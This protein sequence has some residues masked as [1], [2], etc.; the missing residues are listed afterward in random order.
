[1]VK[2]KKF[3][4]F[5]G[6]FTPSI[7]TIL[8]VIM[9]LRLPW[10]IGQ[11]G[12]WATLGIILV[13]HIISLSTGLSVASVA[14]DKQVETGGSYYIISRSLGLSI[15]GT[16]G[17]ALF[18]GLSFSVSLYLIGFAETFLSYFGF[19]VSLFTIRIAGSIILFLVALVTFISTSLAI[20]T[21]YLIMTAMVL[22]LVSVFFGR[23]DFVPAEPLFQGMRG[24]LPW[25][26]LFAIYFPAV[27]GFEAGVSMSGDLKN[28]RKDIP[29]GTISAIL[30]GLVV[31]IGLAFFFSHTVERDLLVNDPNVLFNIS[32]IPQLVIAGILGATLSSA[33]G[34]ILGA[35]RILQAV[36]IDRIIPRFLGKGY[37]PSNEP[38]NALMIT[39]VIAQAGI[40]IG[41]LNV[42][43]RVVTIFFIIT[44]GFL[45]ITYAVESWASSDFRPSFK[46][47]RFVSI[48]GALAC[49]VVMI[50]LDIIALLVASVV[51][52]ALFL[53]LKRKELTLQTGDTWNSVWT[54]VVKTGLEK[55]TASSRESR[56]WRP[57]V[58][59]FS[60]GE[61]S[62]PHLIEMGKS[63]VGKLGIFTN[64]ELVEDPNSD[65]IFREH[66]KNTFNAPVLRK[67]GV[68]T[69]RH[70]CRDFYE[71]IDLI[72]RVYGFSG[73][74]PNTIFMG[75]GRKTRD[76]Q[77]FAQL[78]ENFKKQD[79]NT[80][81]LNYNSDAGFGNYKQ[82]DF[83]WTGSG[84]NLSLAL[85]LLRF[86]TSSKEWMNASLRILVINQDSSK[87]ESLYHLVQQLLDQSRL[88]ASVKVIN[89]GVEQ[90]P[91]N[92]II[93]SESTATD[94]TILEL[95]EPSKKGV[96][97]NEKTNDL[98]KDLK[99]CL[100]VRASTFFD[101]INLSPGRTIKEKDPETMEKHTPNVLAKLTSPSR[102]IVAK[103]VFNL[104]ETLEDMTSR[105]YSEAYEAVSGDVFSFY[106]DLGNY[107]GKIIEQLRKV[108]K[109]VE[110]TAQPKAF[111]RIL[112][113][114]SFQARKRIDFLKGIIVH[115]QEQHLE[116][117]N[118]VYVRDSKLMLESLPEYLRIQLKKEDFETVS[119]DKFWTSTYKSFQRFR[120]KLRGKQ[121]TKKIRV[122]EVARYFLYLR[123]MEV[124]GELMND[125]AI[126]AFG[127]V[128]ALRKI[129]TSL[130]EVIEMT[131]IEAGDK[132]K[133][134]EKLNLEKDRIKAQLSLLESEARAFRIEAGNKLFDSLL[135]DLQ[136]FSNYLDN[137]G[138]NP[139]MKKFLKAL[140]E[141]KQEQEVTFLELPAL[142]E[143]SMNLFINKGVLDF[144]FLSLR[145][146][147][148]S[149][150]R[151]Y[152]LDFSQLIETNMLR[153]LKAYQA[154]L[155]QALEAS[156]KGEPVEK[157]LDHSLL[158]TPQ[159]LKLYAGFFE[160]VKELLGEMPEEI[161][162]SGQ[163]FTDAIEKGALPE[164]DPVVV[165][166][167]KLSGFY[168]SSLLID[169]VKGQGQD[170]EYQFQLSVNRIKDLLRLI[171]FSLQMD[172]E[173]T[174]GEE[175]ESYPDETAKLLKDFSSRLKEEENKVRTFLS[176]FFKTF[177]EGLRQSFEPLSSAV[178]NQ[179]NI[180]LKK[181]MREKGNGRFSR[182]VNHQAEQFREF[183]QKNLVNLLYSKSEG[184]VWAN[185]FEKS[186]TGKLANRDLLSFVEA[187]TPR[188]QIMKELPYY[189]ATLFSGLSGTSDDFWVGM[190]E[191]I[192]EGTQAIARFKVG[193]P[194]I[195]V[196]TG[197]R[198]S[199]KSSLSK[200][201]ARKHFAQEHIHSIRAPKS[202]EA[203]LGAFKEAIAQTLHVQPDKLVDVMSA[204]PAGKVFIIHDLELW[205]ERKPG[206]LQVIEWIK[207]IIDLYGRKFLF[208]INI[209]EHSLKIVDKSTGIL[210]YSLAAVVCKPFDARELQDIILLRHHAGG[211]K[212][213]YNKKEESKMTAWDYARMFNRYFD[214]SFGN[215]G[216]QISLWL[217]S[218]KKITARTI[219][220]EPIQVPP[221]SVFEMLT[222]EQ[223]FYILQFIMH[224]RFSVSSLALSLQIS[225]SIVKDQVN[226]LLRAALII[227][228]F[229]GVYAIN[230]ALDIYLVEQLKKKNLL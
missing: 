114:F 82:I 20:K 35:P 145:S 8:G 119:R 61:L 66:D 100:L 139:R 117:A 220:M 217:S 206:G 53:F 105:Y 104:G 128:V 159:V 197:E 210:N 74:E 90:L 202:C 10:I 207:E 31:Y 147:I 58:I 185:R 86:I 203:D 42:I 221:D 21:Q 81:F 218:I 141:K 219:Y 78:L 144:M 46:I 166:V 158:N 150:I 138:T 85:T 5:G 153:P 106:S 148:H 95:P 151:K 93:L 110:P 70:H 1:M 79:Y 115:T 54:S 205:W 132:D 184:I 174:E 80:V 34:S 109:T 71:G 224:R 16:L 88:Q 62:R 18:V 164:P 33:L 25:I 99:T 193:I 6:V 84:R 40:L 223:L 116:T 194:G 76:P 170:T 160:E 63:L 87:T 201:L 156:E 118:K 129:F 155:L 83:W 92:E 125:Y 124:A 57:N 186:Q 152:N 140:I 23:H 9:Y 108:I 45:N 13:A 161:E 137:A 97:I 143:K 163:N 38:R 199:G 102:H 28:A 162:I 123:R 169:K 4:A 30:V 173:Q 14:T 69:R 213:V 107:V 175:K 195:L 196:I 27:T 154:D 192:A 43:A 133:A 26:A 39:Y 24:A 216:L 134:L 227:E 230:P 208:I 49:I 215:P 59:L 11:A 146:R 126:D 198:S 12:L 41:E 36:A 37:G 55:L 32:W 19:E 103:E 187:V 51:L 89:N 177:E 226:D 171:N 214:Q 204:L 200:Y 142:W 3:G 91:E 222:Q 211:L 120:V 228:K 75:W 131:R 178:I 179:T 176:G 60:G 212:F 113:D 65:A 229:E 188:A 64:F 29:L 127:D 189:Y 225:E 96:S 180:D 77:K 157:Q 121:I 182:W 165:K 149:K 2:A 136:Q 56:N 190:N 94:L 209:N 22:S 112:N 7:L 181:K 73:F 15:G 167:R 191:Q 130:H 67:E 183:G 172:V 122:S 168:L 17:L 135:D 47:P 101:E 68:F 48:I 98:V 52:M 50:Q 111:L 72:S 44:Y